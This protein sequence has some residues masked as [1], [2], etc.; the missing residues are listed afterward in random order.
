VGYHQ[1]NALVALGETSERSRVT[2]R[3]RI[4]ALP[5]G[6]RVAALVLPLP[7]AILLDRLS[8]E[9]AN[10]D[11]VDIRIDLE[12]DVAAAQREAG[13]LQCP[14]EPR[15]HADVD[16]DVRELL[17]E[18]PGLLLAALAQSDLDARVSVYAP[19]DVQHGLAVPRQDE[20]PQTLVRKVDALDHDVVVR[21]VVSVARQLG[22]L[23]R[24]I[25]AARHASE[26]GV[27][28]VQPGR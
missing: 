24:D 19:L 21:P 7:R 9:L 4:E 3:S 10:V 6:K 23:V 14:S 27:L 2:Q 12:G 28:A 25:Q 11:V 5:A 13:R 17:A 16:W 26:D 18:P 20:E 15:V 22:D 8:L 1:R